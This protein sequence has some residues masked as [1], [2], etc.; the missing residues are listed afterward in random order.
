MKKLSKKS[1]MEILG[2]AIIIALIAIGVLFVVKFVLLQPKPEVKTEFTQS[3]LTANMLNVLTRSTTKD[4]Y[5]ASIAELFQDCRVFGGSG[6]P[7]SIKCEN[8]LYSCDYLNNLLEDDCSTS[9]NP[10]SV[11]C[12]TLIDWNK[13]FYFTTQPSLQNMPQEI[14]SLN[15][16]PNQIGAGEPYSTLEQ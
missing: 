15:C 16:G 10:Q 8:D 5:G 14:K 6:N 1:Q 12:K 11:F 13:P 4:C 3:Q 9:G 2:L 7:G